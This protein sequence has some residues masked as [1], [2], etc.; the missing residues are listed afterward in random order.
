MDETSKK[1]LTQLEF[2]Q[3]KNNLTKTFQQLESAWDEE[4]E[5]RME[6]ERLVALHDKHKD[7]YTRN[8]DIEE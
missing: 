4:E 2:N 3:L 7:E 1:T 6:R 8:H 5:K